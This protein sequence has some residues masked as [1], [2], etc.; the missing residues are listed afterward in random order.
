MNFLKLIF[1]KYF[2]SL[3]NKENPFQ[4]D[5]NA[6]NQSNSSKTSNNSAIIE[7]P[8]LVVENVPA[9]KQP[10]AKEN[11]IGKRTIFLLSSFVVALFVLIAGIFVGIFGVFG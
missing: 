7:R 4:N 1:T 3:A 11:F 9:K 8:C 2:K 5:K 10:T 6:K